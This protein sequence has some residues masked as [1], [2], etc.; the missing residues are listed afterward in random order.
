MDLCPILRLQSSQL[1]TFW[2]NYGTPGADTYSFLLSLF[3]QG[4]KPPVR[5]GTE[6]SCHWH[7]NLPQQNQQA[8]W[9]PFN[10]HLAS[11]RIV[12]LP[13]GYSYFNRLFL[14][15]SWHS[16][17]NNLGSFV[18]LEHTEWGKLQASSR[19][20]MQCYSKTQNNFYI[21]RHADDLFNL[22]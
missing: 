3:L 6:R 9:F 4:H 12:Q 14:S 7:P 16:Y 13:I 5:N 21:A 15:D 1:L 11:N 8:L 17:E 22:N 19:S 2:M 20:W 10:L 18:L